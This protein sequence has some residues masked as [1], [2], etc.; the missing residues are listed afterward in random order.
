MR[1][2]TVALFSD[3]KCP[4]PVGAQIAVELAQQEGHPAK[5]ECNDR[6][7][8]AQ[9]SSPGLVLHQVEGAACWWARSS[10][11]VCTCAGQASGYRSVCSVRHSIAVTSNAAPHRDASRCAWR[12]PGS[13]DGRHHGSLID[14]TA[15]R[16]TALRALDAAWLR[17]RCAI[18]RR[19]RRIK[20]FIRQPAPASRTDSNAPIPASVPPARVAKLVDAPGLG[21]DASN[22]VR[23]RVPPRAPETLLEERANHHAG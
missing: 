4:A 7:A 2:D 15:S 19:G 6:F 20:L 1:L 11:I 16:L 3:P 21:P 10:T 23:V 14:V 22:G 18:G 17:M 12:V 13:T 5:P 8:A 9:L